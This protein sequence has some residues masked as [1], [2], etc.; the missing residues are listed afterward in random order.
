M[1]FFIYIILSLSA[2]LISRFVWYLV[3]DNRKRFIRSKGHIDNIEKEIIE[4]TDKY[5]LEHF[6]LKASGGFSLNGYIKS[7]P[8]KK[9][10]LPAVILL[11]GLF[12][13]KMVV[14]FVDFNPVDTPVFMISTD[15]PYEGEK[16]LK[17]WQIIFAVPRIR[18]AAFNSISGIF[19][20]IDML[21]Q[22]DFIDKD[23]IYLTGVS[24]GSFF[25]IAAAAC[26]QKIKSVASI[27]SGSKIEKLVEANLPYKMKLFNKTVGIL[28][29]LLVYPLEPLHYVQDI[30]PR[31]FLVMGGADDERFPVK[32]TEKLYDKANDPK[33]LIWIKSNHMEPQKTELI[34]QLTKEVTIWMKSRDLI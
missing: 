32:Y 9:E 21:E 25:C 4:E 2:I 20:T 18:K 13:G 12:S 16:R 29:K 14:D 1:N 15:Y 19:L 23:R 10:K 8:E 24:F 34:S 5:I 11:G 27:Y 7:P 6:T 33:D 28:V 17:W 3:R 22:I 26:T 31:P 30:S